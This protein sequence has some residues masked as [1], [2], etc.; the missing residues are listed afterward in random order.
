MNSRIEKD[1]HFQSA[2]FHTGKFL[3]NSYVITLSMLVDECEHAGEPG[4]AIERM[5]YFIETQIQNCLFIYDQE[6]EQIELYKNSGI[7]VCLLP[8]EPN[9]ELVAAILVLKLNAIME[10]RIKITD[11][12]ISSVLGEG[13]RFI[14]VSEV[15]ETSLPDSQWYNKP[16]ISISNEEVEYHSDGNIVKLFTND[17]WSELGMD[18]KPEDL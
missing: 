16:C 14:I 12:T 10:E 5:S 4:I 6:I 3:I 18:W 1:F 15:A 11:M 13:V 7:R 8:E 2:I 17:Q 9:D